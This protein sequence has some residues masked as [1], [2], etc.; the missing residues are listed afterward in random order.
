[1]AL[2]VHQ[3]AALFYG[4]GMLNDGAG[5]VFIGCVNCGCGRIRQGTRGWWKSGINNGFLDWH[6]AIQKIAAYSAKIPENYL[7]FPEI[8][9][10]T[11]QKSN[12]VNKAL[13]KEDRLLPYPG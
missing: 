13:Y 11:V 6:I 12:P 1:M 9:P 10:V 4:S 3:S 8:L 2:K 7:L 5:C